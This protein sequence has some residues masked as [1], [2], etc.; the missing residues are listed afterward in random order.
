MDFKRRHIGLGLAALLLVL[1]GFG[2]ARWSAPEAPAPPPTTCFEPDSTFVEKVVQRD[3]AYHW[4]SPDHP[5]EQLGKHFIAA[6]FLPRND[7]HIGDGPYPVR[8]ELV[9]A[10][11]TLRAVFG[12]AI[13]INSCVRSP[14]KQATLSDARNSD[15]LTGDAVDFTVMDARLFKYLK[16]DLRLRSGW[17]RHWLQAFGIRGFGIYAGHVH[18]GINERAGREQ[19]GGIAYQFW[20]YADANALHHASHDF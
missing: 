19:C 4:I 3:T 10:L 6:E 18:L 16:T 17:F 15:H 2:L 12:V 9:A 13:V 1:L 8:K 14:Q 5:F 20:D 11:D 7:R